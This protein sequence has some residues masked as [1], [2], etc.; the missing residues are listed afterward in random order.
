[1][2]ITAG[3]VAGAATYTLAWSCGDRRHPPRVGSNGCPWVM[4]IGLSREEFCER[5]DIVS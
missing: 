1:M 3:E 4:P 5:S 2:F